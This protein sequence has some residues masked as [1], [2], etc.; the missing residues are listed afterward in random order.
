MNMSKILGLN[1]HGLILPSFPYPTPLG[2][3][4]HDG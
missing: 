2:A 4:D 3:A 1:S